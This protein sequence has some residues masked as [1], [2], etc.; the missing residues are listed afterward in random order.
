MSRHH[1][2]LAW[3]PDWVSNCSSCWCQVGRFLPARSRLVGPVLGWSVRGSVPLVPLVPTQLAALLLQT[4]KGRTEAG[5]RSTH[6]LILIWGKC[7]L[8]S[9]KIVIRWWAT[10]PFTEV[11]THLLGRWNQSL[12]FW[13]CIVQLKDISSHACPYLVGVPVRT[14]N[15]CDTGSV[16]FTSQTLIWRFSSRL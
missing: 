6:Q 5:W 16:A 10:F 7:I 9:F 12:C 3:R 2:W 8:Y 11:E 15:L 1:L 4:H 13:H 14:L